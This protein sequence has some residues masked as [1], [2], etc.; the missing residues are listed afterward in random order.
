[1]SG[2]TISILALCLVLG[3]AGTAFALSDNV[4][5]N[6]NKSYQTVVLSPSAAGSSATGSASVSV[7]QM[8]DRYR[9]SIE[10]RVNKLVPQPGTVY[11]AWLV[12]SSNNFSQPIGAFGTNAS[13]SGTL[14]FRED[15]VNPGIFDKIEIT[16][17]AKN[18]TNP[19]PGTEAMSGSIAPSGTL[20]EIVT[21]KGNM[22][23]M[24]EAPPNSSAAT[25]TGT[26]M[27]NTSINELSYDV[28]FSGLEGT[29]TAA[30]LHGPGSYGQNAPIM[31]TLPM[32]SHVTGT[33][34]VSQS[35]E[36][37]ILQ[38]RTYMN[39]KTDKYPNGEIRGQL[40]VTG[41]Q[42]SG[43][44]DYPEKQEAGDGEDQKEGNASSSQQSDNEPENEG[45]GY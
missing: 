28:Q 2:K 34:N 41:M 11:E 17:Q 9:V 27:L 32:G 31:F 20:N 26:F 30:T 15:M 44:G 33:L 6:A 10:L 7:A 5:Q 40:L 45:G 39:I 43:Q 21:L 12:S 16:S 42:Q 25:G 19:A 18:G 29:E 4:A 13:G 35:Q 8:S 38:G 23:P 36:Q 3:L 22:G 37:K 14:T 24:Q 1:M